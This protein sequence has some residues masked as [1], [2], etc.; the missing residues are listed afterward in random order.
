MY[1]LVMVHVLQQH[2][3]V[4]MEIHTL[5]RMTL[6]HNVLILQHMV[7]VILK[8]ILAIREQIQKEQYSLVL[9]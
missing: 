6:Y 2:I 4:Q 1:A 7:N 8:F 5:H 3:L 9:E